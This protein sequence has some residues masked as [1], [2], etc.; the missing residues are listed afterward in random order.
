VISAY[1]DYLLPH[2]HSRLLFLELKG[3]NAKKFYLLLY[4]IPFRTLS[5]ST[6]VM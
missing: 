3:L 5:L 6:P 4:A 1:L 2:L